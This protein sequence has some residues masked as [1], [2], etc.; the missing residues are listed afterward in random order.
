MYWEK[1]ETF[2]SDKALGE[3]IRQT[4]KSCGLSQMQLADRIGISYQQVQKYERGINR[5][6]LSRIEQIAEALGMPSSFF[7]DEEDPRKGGEPNA[8]QAIF[9]EEAR[10]LMLYRGLR[11]KKLKRGFLGMI[12][13]FVKMLPREKDE[14]QEQI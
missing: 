5:L 7:L 10:L 11:S 13:D 12:E 1:T 6:T 9:K 2:M 14:P 3:L 4:R 8:L